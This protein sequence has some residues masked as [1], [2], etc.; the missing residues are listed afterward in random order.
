MEQFLKKVENFT[1]KATLKAEHAGNANAL[2]KEANQRI[3][4]ANA[5]M[6]QLTHSM[7]DIS[8]ASKETSKI[9]KTIDKIAFR[10][11]LLALN[12]AVEAARAGEAGAGFAV[13]ADEVR[14]LAMR[15]A[16]AAKNTAALIEGTVKKMNDVSTLVSITSEAFG[17][18]AESTGKVGQIVAKI[19]RASEDHANGIE[20]I[21]IAISEMDK[22]GQQNA[23][24]CC[25][26]NTTG[27]N[28]TI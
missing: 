27:T 23:G 4:T 17:T 9:I 5:S 15:A 20:K 21:N 1:Q 6:D 3:K 14:N 10:T 13:V 12:A 25:K 24:P 2:M 8:R 11:N 18:E 22:V 19:F 26:S 28:D 16:N 7:E